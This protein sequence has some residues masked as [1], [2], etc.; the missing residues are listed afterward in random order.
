MLFKPH[1]NTRGY[2]VQSRERGDVILTKFEGENYNKKS[3]IKKE[4]SNRLKNK[5]IYA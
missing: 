5:P 1:K 2:C 3:H 4:T